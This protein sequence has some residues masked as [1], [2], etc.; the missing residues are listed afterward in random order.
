[1]VCIFHLC[2]R[3]CCPQLTRFIA[4]R[5]LAEAEKSQAQALAERKVTEG[6]LSVTEQK[7]RDMEA[8]IEEDSRESSDLDLL[9]QRLAEELQD[10]REQHQKDLSE[11]DFTADQTR[12][13]YQGEQGFFQSSLTIS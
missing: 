11:R 5:A 6:R 2:I 10:E 8:K 7:L 1:M 9:K 4:R 3:V 13:K 12:K